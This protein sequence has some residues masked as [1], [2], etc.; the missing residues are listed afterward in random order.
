MKK[1]K[2]FLSI[3]LSLLMIISAMP[4][5]A[6]NAFADDDSLG[7]FVKIGSSITSV[8]HYCYTMTELKNALN[9]TVNKNTNKKYVIN[10]EHEVTLTEPME[11]HGNVVLKADTGLTSKKDSK[12]TCLI[13]NYGK[14]SIM[15]GSNLY[16]DYD[17][18]HALVNNYGEL[19]ISNSNDGNAGE[20]TNFRINK[21]CIAPIENQTG[22]KLYIDGPMD[23][24][25][26]ANLNY[27]IFNYNGGYVKI[28]TDEFKCN[29]PIFNAGDATMDIYGGYY[30]FNAVSITSRDIENKGTMNIYSGNFY[31]KFDNSGTLNIYRGTFDGAFSN[32]G[33]VNAYSAVFND[34]FTNN[35]VAS[36]S[37]A[38]L[39]NGVE[40][41][42]GTL[43]QLLAS[44]AYYYT[45]NYNKV[46][47][48]KVSTYSG[49]LG[50]AL[51][52]NS[53]FVGADGAIRSLPKDDILQFL[54]DNPYID[55]TLTLANGLNLSNSEIY[56]I[57]VGNLT[58]T[59][60]ATINSHDI[61]GYFQNDHSVL[62]IDGLT[63]IHSGTDEWGLNAGIRN[64]ATVNISNATLKGYTSGTY[65]DCVVYNE[66]RTQI[67]D[68]VIDGTIADGHSPLSTWLAPC[69]KFV[70]KYGKTVDLSN[71]QEYSGYLKVVPDPSAHNWEP[72]T[73]SK[74]KI[75]TICGAAE[76]PLDPTV[77]NWQEATCSTPQTCSDCGATQGETLPHTFDIY[78]DIVSTNPIVV[79]AKCSVCGEINENYAIE[80]RVY[81]IS[82]DSNSRFFK[83][84]KTVKA[85]VKLSFD[86]R[87]EDVSLMFDGKDIP[88]VG[89]N[90][91]YTIPRCAKVAYYSASSE[92]GF[93]TIRIDADCVYT[94]QSCKRPATCIYCGHTKGGTLAH[95]YSKQG[96]LIS[97]AN[98]T[99]PA[100]YEVMC[101]N[102]D[103]VSGT[104]EVGE[105][106]PTAHNWK[107]ATCTAPKT[108]TL[109]Y[110]TEGE[111][112]P[113]AHNWK[114]ATCTEPKTCSFCYTTE[115]EPLPHD[116]DLIINDYVY[117]YTCKT[118]DD[119]YIVD[120]TALASIIALANDEYINNDL[121]S[122]MYSNISQLKFMVALGNATLD[123]ETAT[124]SNVDSIARTVQNAIN[125]LKLKT[126]SVTVNKIVDDEIAQTESTTVAYG[127]MFNYF[128]ELDENQAIYKWVM[129][130]DERDVK[131][132]TIAQDFSQVINGNV[133][134]NCYID[135]SDT[136]AEDA[137]RVVFYDKGN[138]VIAFEYV[139]IGSSISYNVEAPK[140]AFY[141]FIGW[142]TVSGD[143]TNVD[144]SGVSL[145][146][147]YVP[148]SNTCKIIGLNGVTVNGKTEFDAYYDQMLTLA[149]AEHF[150]YC[151]ADGNILQG[152]NGNVIYAPNNV[153]TIYVC[154]GTSNKVST[155]IT[156]YIDENSKLTI[157]AQ[158][159]L[160]SGS[161]VVEA[162]VIATNGDKS[163]TFKSSQ[164]GSSGEYSI[165]LNYGSASGTLNFKSYLT[166]K[167]TDGIHTIY[168]ES[169]AIS[170]GQNT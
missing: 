124:Q 108:C 72:A 4:L 71:T 43:N 154:A 18:I 156:G 135:N 39:K 17:S 33:T 96:A 118:C 10:I 90:T 86:S 44:D 143:P 2:K 146:A 50:V 163:N 37:S 12:C 41:T 122:T 51:S 76:G 128:V 145:R 153:Q 80:D 75:C 73:C 23:I 127:E 169:Q 112:N 38:S 77:H 45:G 162:G 78:L 30:K 67:K 81:D 59:G 46:D 148:K 27:S 115:G 34:K 157:N 40:N 92:H 15:Q 42:K 126:Y 165:S 52:T 85:G 120:K 98:C 66:G 25:T 31:D 87:Y 102:C 95:D 16:Q 11:L 138:R 155:S 140:V 113:S 100:I 54:Y 159:Y 48:S 151:D 158:Y 57:F 20:C 107:D 134:F 61:F 5:S 110:A 104:M 89:P 60:N 103:S 150:A 152:I 3:L 132:N 161:S 144:K 1:T 119:S 6:I 166:Y 64:K 84:R 164:Q 9:N 168:S 139:T 65:K 94:L 136:K 19:H 58:I 133:T 7:G 22:G 24:S 26:Y 114:E 109:C 160:P 88:N 111:I 142:E 14:L 91:T 83:D 74:L 121:A 125:N 131:L 28:N 29:D 47:L 13:E 21:R 68:S 55:G 167:D 56:D 137:A 62:N 147:T 82:N 35:G 70:D 149:G 69:Y 53:V 93:I 106:N 141:D 32:T 129:A 36:L 117:T 116:Y 123:S 97:E 99:N 8:E 101:A 170:F 130:T 49:S 63:I 105:V 79:K